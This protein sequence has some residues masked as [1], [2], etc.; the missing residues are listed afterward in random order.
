MTFNALLHFGAAFFCGGLAFFGLFR[1]YRSFVHQIFAFGMVVLAL[2]SAFTGLSVQALFAEEVIF[3]QRWRCVATALL[4]GTWLLFSLSFPRGDD[5]PTLGTWKW[6]ILAAFLLHLTFVTLFASRFFRDVPFFDPLQGWLLSLGWSGYAFHISFLVGAVLIMMLLEKTLRAS[7]G[8]QRWQVKFLAIGIGALFAA[9]VY[10]GSQALLLHQLNLE[11]EMVNGAGLLV[12]CFLILISILRAQLLHMDI[13]L[14]QT[15]LYRSFTLLIVGVY[16][17]GVGVL[18]KAVGDVNSGLALT[19]QAFFIFLAL[20]SLLI[21]LLS[22]RLRLRMRQ[23]ISRHFQR[24]QYDYRK[25]WMAFTERT[26]S[27]VE[28]KPFCDAVAK[29]V[30]EM[31]DI[32]SVSIWLRDETRQGL[33]LGGSTAFSDTQATDLSGFG[34]GA[35]D[36]IRL[37]R[38]EQTIVDLE[39]TEAGEA[40][41]LRRSHMRFLQDA[42]IRYCIPL[43]SGGDLLGLITLGDRVRGVPFSFEELDMLKTIAD[44]VAASLMNLKL[45]EQ[46]QQAKEMQAFQTVAALFAHDLKNLASKLSL[47]LQNL[48]AHFDNPAF[49]EDALRAIS[50]S[51]GKI[52]GMCSRLSLVREGP[53]L[54]PIEADLNELVTTTLVGL[55]GILKASL[56]EDL[57]PLP[58]V[59]LD[60]KQIPKVL[61]NLILNA[62]AAV[63]DGGKIHVTTGTR[64]GWVVLTVSDNG[65]GMSK[66]FLDQCLFRPFRTTKK[67]GTGIGLLQSKMIVDAHKGRIEVE[68]QEGR[69]STFRVLLPVKGTGA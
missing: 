33:K 61:T 54:R 10:T 34:H 46:L 7:R 23:L 22:D 60:P 28:R 6:I 30:S 9:R 45:S 42:R 4:P 11:L 56:V 29:M 62:D 31:L 49:R 41:A 40:E 26:A 37:V 14:S 5:K 21:V 58:R 44:Q 50:Q 51:V 20:L 36:L 69:G 3:W 52:N 16:L 68:S 67:Q 66:E 13:Y 18:A 53:E 55:N 47:L 38:N 24:P 59:S 1:D 64:D 2:E 17:L 35:A 27:L 48:P 32:L 8:R 25:A 12:A 57:H 63:D 43:V 65:C 15:I 19:I 39:N